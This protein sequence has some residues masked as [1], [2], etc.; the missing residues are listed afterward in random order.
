V[1]GKAIAP[2]NKDKLR[3]VPPI[4][5]L[6]QSLKFLWIGKKSKI[7]LEEAQRHQIQNNPLKAKA[8]DLKLFQ[9]FEN[10]I[11]YS[12]LE[13]KVSEEVS[14][15]EAY[16]QNSNS[17]TKEGTKSKAKSPR[18]VGFRNNPISRPEVY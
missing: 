18:E 4:P 8:T 14:P 16:Y 15:L 12:L 1:K 7:R 9:G 17:S 13:N 2:D 11:L 10:F 5:L 3:Q 6:H